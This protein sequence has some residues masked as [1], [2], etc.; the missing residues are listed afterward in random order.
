MNGTFQTTWNLLFGVLGPLMIQEASEPTLKAA[1]DRFVDDQNRAYLENLK[2]P[3]FKLSHFSLNDDDF[4][5]IKVQFRAL[6]LITKSEKSRSVKDVET[7]W[8]LTPYGDEVMTRIKAIKR[9]TVPNEA[10]NDA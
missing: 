10:Q 5:T 4:Q 9:T 8:T 1:I 3:G 7:Y 6:G 2:M